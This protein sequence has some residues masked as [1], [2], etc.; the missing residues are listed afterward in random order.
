MKSIISL[1]LAF[2]LLLNA[3]NLL[4]AQQTEKELKKN[5]SSKATR[6]A[7]VEAKKYKRAGYFVAPGA[8][9]LDKQ[10]EN[11]WLKLYETNDKNE[12][13]YIMASGNS[14]GE[15]QIAAKIQATEVAK[16]ELAGQISTKIAALV[17]NSIANQQLN[18]ADAAS[19]T[20]TVMASKSII[21][22][23]IGQV[24]PLVE[25]YRHIGKNTEVNIRLAYNVATA[26]DIAK[27]VI[28][29]KLEEEA[30]IGH[31]KLKGI[32]DSL[33]PK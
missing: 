6:N 7:R 24:F 16:L 18:N 29:Q 30:N 3:A 22:Q 27:K 25:M 2:A 5:V 26:F 23:E 21:A 20:K 9:M 10:L 15:S 13:K 1:F 8:F 33:P 14:V 12:P 32:M 11:A 4:L 19:V 28:R 31:D 17:E